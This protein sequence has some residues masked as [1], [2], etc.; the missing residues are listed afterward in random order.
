M[1]KRKWSFSKIYLHFVWTTKNRLAVIDKSIKK[2]I[3]KVLCSKAKDLGIQIIEANGVAD[4]FHA[5]VESTPTISPS[6]IAKN[7]KG[8]SAH[9]VNHVTLKEDKLRSLYWQDGYGVVSVSPSAVKSIG[10]YIRSQEVH[11][12]EGSSIE[13]YEI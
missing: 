1:E 7:F 2:D 12:S 6:D 10:E 5:L 8:S 11:H 13:E 9:F 3:I 4:H